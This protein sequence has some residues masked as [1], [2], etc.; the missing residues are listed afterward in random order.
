MKL[1]AIRVVET[2]KFLGVD[3]S[4]NDGDFCCGVEFIFYPSKLSMI[5]VWMIENK[6]EA[7]RAIANRNVEWYNAAYFTPS[8]PDGLQNVELEVVEINI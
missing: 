1:Y 4:R 7:E 5:P 2:G 6:V 3:Y 8:F